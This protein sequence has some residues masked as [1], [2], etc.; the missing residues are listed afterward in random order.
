M[1]RGTKLTEEEKIQ[2]LCF[3]NEGLNHRK[4]SKQVNRSKTVVT[5]FL[6]DPEGYNNKKRPGRPSKI[7]PRHLRRLFNKA[8]KGN[9]SSS[10]LQKT[11]DIP[12]SSRRIR[13]L[14]N[15]SKRFKYVKKKQH[16]I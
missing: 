3:K 7:T 14:L 9:L 15:E 1:P 12:V 16:Q 13:Q 6:A 2:I 11:I 5:N 8:S 4:F 10:E